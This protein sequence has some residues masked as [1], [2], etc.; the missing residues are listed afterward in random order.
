MS[1]PNLN[2]EVESIPL[3]P[4]Q[5]AVKN[6]SP[7]TGEVV[8]S[9]K[10]DKE[11]L[12]LALETVISRHD[13]FKQA[14]SKVPGFIDEQVIARSYAAYS[15]V[16][17]ESSV[18]EQAE[19][20]RIN[21]LDFSDGSNI[22]IVLEKRADNDVRLHIAVPSIVAD[23]NSLI[24]FISEVSRIYDGTELTEPFQYSQFAAWRR[25]LEEDAQ[26][27]LSYWSSYLEEWPLP[28][29]L[30][31]HRHGFSSERSSLARKLNIHLS[32]TLT[33]FAKQQDVSFETLVQAA[34]WLL[35]ARLSGQK[36]YYANWLHDCRDDYEIMIDGIGVFEKRLPLE[37]N[38]DLDSCFDSWLL[39]LK[40][41]LEKHREAQEFW[42]IDEARFVNDVQVGFGFTRIPEINSEMLTFSFCS[43]PSYY[44]MASLYL[45]AIRS[46]DGTTFVI[47]YDPALYDPAVIESLFDQYEKLLGNIAKCPQAAMRILTSESQA[48]A[49]NGTPLDCGSM[50]VFHRVEYWMHET[51]DA[52]AIRFGTT[53]LSYLDFATK[54]GEL[55]SFLISNGVRPGVK[56]ALCANR[57]ERLI[58][59]LFAAWRV[60]AIY[61]P[62][63]PSWPEARKQGVIID[64]GALF[65][66][67]G[68]Q[69]ISCE[70]QSAPLP[71]DN[72]EEEPAYVIYTS[73][74]TGLPKGVAIGH[75]ELA[76]YVFG[77]SQSI[78]LA[79]VR[80]WAMIGNLAA[81]LGYTGI[82]GAL[83]N[84]G[85]LVIAEDKDLQDSL[86]FSRFIATNNI[87]GIKIVPSQ[88]DALLDNSIDMALP[89]KLVLG[90][91]PSDMRL[92]RRIR[93]IAPDNEIYNH[94][95][96]TET[97]IG[98]MIGLVE[99]GAPENIEP[100]AL[101]T[102]LPNNK[103]YILDDKLNSVLSGG[104]GEL[105]IGGKQLGRY[106][107]ATDSNAF[108]DSPF[109][110]NERLYRSG[111]L[112]CYL[113]QG[114]VR[115]LGRA[116]HQIKIRGYR[117]EAGE[118][119][120]ALKLCMG[121]HDAIILY[122]DEQ[123]CA[124]VIGD[125]DLEAKKEFL[126]CSV[127]EHL[128]DYMIPA[129]FIF[130]DKFARLASGKIDRQ[131]LLALPMQ[132][133][134]KALT[135]PCDAVEAF[136]CR[137]MAKLLKRNDI[138]ADQDFFELG[139]HSLLVIKLLARIRQSLEIDLP[140][141]LFFDHTTPQALA[142]Q[143]RAA[144]QKIADLERLAAICRNDEVG[145]QSDV[146]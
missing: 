97:T 83:A 17:D 134:A 82:F 130:V 50:N 110:K 78:R 15:F 116:D 7:I 95:G 101:T 107:K 128:P 100:L 135:P 41:L 140:P 76:N 52:E 48:I 129:H 16:F 27:E 74:S 88:L 24:H 45:N 31:L 112:A 89:K 122:R 32:E 62:L 81:D 70:T 37:V 141:S 54:V 137:T 127:A 94:Y 46:V 10:I 90:G 61:V 28:L 102:V 49:L 35:L 145:L 85:C 34:W 38:I 113:P 72:N 91:E 22:K 142:I 44:G 79:E 118:V 144:S 53:H 131:A 63:D 4:E 99:A 86:S 56:V 8:L 126:R 73:G 75:S 57:S 136:L 98:V 117:V 69:W 120:H 143:L 119:E 29:R 19:K 92:V 55:A 39:Q 40:L 42:P 133:E 106:L 84:G 30:P 65:L 124:Y 5:R 138:G 108:I 146:S 114:G 66:F 1:D 115:L 51:P 36:R 121:V 20:A 9:G 59:A 33:V 67:D 68:D 71:T 111:D 2:R 3:T 139:G 125:D 26:E 18:S 64:C 104:V 60:G 77:A 123:L 13:I 96:P 87:D 105:Y 11:R 21:L 132:Q 103:I 58:I 23:Y 25:S 109:D 6:L 12:R 93:S 43:L 80:C 47:H 14:F